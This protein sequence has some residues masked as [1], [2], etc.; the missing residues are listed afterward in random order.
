MRLFNISIIRTRE[1]DRIIDNTEVIKE[2]IMKTQA[3][4]NS[5]VQEVLD[6]VAG[7]KEALL[8]AIAQ[9]KAELAELVEEGIELFESLKGEIATLSDRE[10]EVA[11]LTEIQDALA[12]SVSVA[13]ISGVV[14]KDALQAQIDALNPPAPPVEPP[15]EPVV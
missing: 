11:R 3:E 13:D 2:L 14:D 4:F 8:G 9:E 6:Q 15:V 5:K 1:L 10:A 12:A 7:S